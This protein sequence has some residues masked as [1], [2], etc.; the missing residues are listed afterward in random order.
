MS[1][2][3]RHICVPAHIYYNNTR[4]TQLSAALAELGL[5][6]SLSSSAGKLLGQENR[7]RSVKCGRGWGWGG[8][9]GGGAD[10]GRGGSLDHR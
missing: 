7:E 9:V 3:H 10:G 5:R 6:G 8:G 4:R 1:S 2:V